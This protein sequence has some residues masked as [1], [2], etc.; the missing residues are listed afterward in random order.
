MDAAASGL[1]RSAGFRA[2]PLGVSEAVRR[3]REKVRCG[4]KASPAGRHARNTD[5]ARCASRARAAPAEGVKRSG[6][7]EPDCS[8]AAAPEPPRLSA[9]PATYFLGT[10]TDSGKSRDDG[11]M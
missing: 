7:R 11:P 8:P 1:I 4:R 5:R 3:K 2:A 6:L 9:P 10:G